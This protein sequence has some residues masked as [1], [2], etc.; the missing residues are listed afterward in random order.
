MESE[1]ERRSRSKVLEEVRYL[2][3]IKYFLHVLFVKTTNK[4]REHSFLCLLY[5]EDNYRWFDEPFSEGTARVSG[6]LAVNRQNNPIVRSKETM[7]YQRRA[8]ATTYSPV[9]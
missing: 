4:A 6:M 3:K 9:L 8:T 7:P 1:K 5:V 2:A